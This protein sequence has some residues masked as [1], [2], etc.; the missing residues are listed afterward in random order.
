MLCKIP[1]RIWNTYDIEHMIYII[2]QKKSKT[3]LIEKDLA[4]ARNY[5]LSSREYTLNQETLSKDTTIPYSGYM[6]CEVGCATRRIFL[7]K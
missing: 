2:I 6:C 7:V 5:V 1:Y 4:K 3:E